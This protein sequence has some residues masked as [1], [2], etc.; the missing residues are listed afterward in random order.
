MTLKEELLKKGIDPDVVEE[1]VSLVESG[2]SGGAIEALQKAL[3]SNGQLSLFKADD[4]DDDDDVV[5]P[6]TDDGDDDGDG[7]NYDESYMKKHMKK[8]MSE[9][10]KA[11]KTMIENFADKSEKLEKAISDMDTSSD[12]AIV[13]MDDL[14]PILS[15]MGDTMEALAKAVHKI[16]DRLE[17]FSESQSE[18][19]DLLQKAS[20]VT[21][22]VAE[23]SQK[24]FSQSQGRRGANAFESMA[25]ASVD[26]AKQPT[27]KSHIHSVLRK[28]IEGGDRTAGEIMSVFESTGMNLTVLKPEEKSYIAK[29][30]EGK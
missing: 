6:E 29:L 3:N 23:N 4:D 15:A 25:K 21:L 20:A 7:D 12:G 24:T 19:Y 5:E 9:N 27:G 28:A 2:R 14:T 16:G 26:A 11:C 30:M 17:E 13:A 18:T 10:Q 1:M 22:A 8:F